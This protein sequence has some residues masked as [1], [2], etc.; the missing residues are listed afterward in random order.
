MPRH[1]I[2]FMYYVKSKEN[3][4]SNTNKDISIYTSGNKMSFGYKY[5]VN[6]PF[7]NQLLQDYKKRNGI[8]PNIPMS[9]AQRKEFDCYVDKFFAEQEI[10]N[11]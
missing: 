9:N 6:H 7:I 11:K 1:I 4:N 2:L 5:N 10:Q 8:A 3:D